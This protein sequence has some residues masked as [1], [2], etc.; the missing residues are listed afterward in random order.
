M[1]LDYSKII[2]GQKNQA[3]FYRKS[4]STNKKKIPGCNSDKKSEFQNLKVATLSLKITIHL[5]L[6]ISEGFRMS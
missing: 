5:I 1:S 2:G 6:R 3:A 4:I